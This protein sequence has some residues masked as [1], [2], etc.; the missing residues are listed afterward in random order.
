MTSSW[1]Q[2]LL[3]HEVALQSAK[4][5]VLF[6][7][8]LTL[9]VLIVLLVASLVIVFCVRY[10]RGSK[11]K[12]GPLPEAMTREWEIGWTGATIFAFVFLFWWAGSLFVTEASPPSGALEIHVVA[13]QWMWKFQH[14]SGVREIDT[15][16]APANTPVKL[17]LTS[18][19]VIH[20]LAIPAFRLKRDAVPGRYNETWFLA[21]KPGVYPLFCTQ[22]CGLDHSAMTGKVIVMPAAAYGAWAHA[23]PSG[24]DLA[25]QGLQ[26]FIALGCAGC[27]VRGSQVR[28]PLLEGVF[29][30]PVP[31]SDGRT[32]IADEGY[33]RD[34]ILLPNKDI[35]AGFA[36]EMPSYQGVASESDVVA[37]VAYLKSIGSPTRSEV[38]R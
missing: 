7:A 12:R 29:G 5:D 37:L 10:R 13:K 20:S 28:A 25:E 1:Q 32:V 23:Q 17:V 6:F 27:H 9:S 15:L 35:V 31:L 11:A 21:T 14:P 33:L 16:H 26:M 4:T 3:P 8:V 22:F 19:D 38:A 18:R 36:P 24:G 30:H 34:S 2:R